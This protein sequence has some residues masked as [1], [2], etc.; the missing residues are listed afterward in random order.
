[1]ELQPPDEV[2][3]MRRDFDALAIASQ[4]ECPPSVAKNYLKHGGVNP[5]GGVEA[6]ASKLIAEK[7]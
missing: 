5:W 1:M 3:Q 6:I 2:A 4:I 7:K